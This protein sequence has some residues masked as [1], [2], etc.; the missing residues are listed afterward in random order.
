[1]STASAVDRSKVLVDIM[2][3]VT[4]NCIGDTEA[5]N[6]VIIPDK[7]EKFT[8]TVQ[9]EEMQLTFLKNVL[10][11]QVRFVILIINL[12]RFDFNYVK[13]FLVFTATLSGNRI[14]KM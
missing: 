4:H 9:H 11:T 1:M 6:R 13:P 12:T 8:T 10:G 7:L 3:N 14:L 5:S 2:A